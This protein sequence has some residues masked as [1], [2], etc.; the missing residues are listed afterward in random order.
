MTQQAYKA[1]QAPQ[2][3][4]AK[5]AWLM[6]PDGVYLKLYRSP[7]D[8]ERAARDVNTKGRAESPAEYARRRRLR[9]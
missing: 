4:Y 1:E 7:E 6:D 2:T 9:A 3:Y 5:D 8:A